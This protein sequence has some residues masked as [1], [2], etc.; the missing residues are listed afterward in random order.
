[1]PCRCAV[2]VCHAGVQ[3]RCA[4]QVCST[5]AQCR[6]ATQ[7][8]HAGVPRRCAEA[9]TSLTPKRWHSYQAVPVARLMRLQSAHCERIQHEPEAGPETWGWTAS[10]RTG[11]GLRASGTVARALATP[12]WV[13]QL[14][15]RPGTFWSPEPSPRSPGLSCFMPVTLFKGKDEDCVSIPQGA[16]ATQTRQ[17]CRLLLGTPDVRGPRTC[18]LPVLLP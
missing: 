5:G 12:D 15:D 2:Q 1:M 10:P 18:L 11:G 16:G 13:L 7:V 17:R 8:C 4:V 14:R 6:C 3:C 9:L